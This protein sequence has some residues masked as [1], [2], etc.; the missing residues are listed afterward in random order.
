MNIFISYS[1][2]DLKT[3][4]QI[5]GYLKPHVDKVQYWD[6][7][8]RPGEKIWDNILKWIDTA[9]LVLALITDNSVSRSPSVDQE[10]GYAK[11]KGKSILPLVKGS[12]DTAK[13]GCL[14]DVTYFII[15]TDDLQPAFDVIADKINEIR[16]KKFVSQGVLWAILGLVGGMLLFGSGEDDYDGIY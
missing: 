13:L 15:D 11:A 9:D 8:K 4:R 6:D 3:V 16:K 2:D 10:I 1:T 5:A 12:V 7:S 14:H